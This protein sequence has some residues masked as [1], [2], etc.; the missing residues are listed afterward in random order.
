MSEL[1]VL[2]NGN[3]EKAP[4]RTLVPPAGP[5]HTNSFQEVRTSLGYSLIVEL[6]VL[7]QAIRRLDPATS[8][9][10]HSVAWEVNL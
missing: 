9:C 2:C 5:Q 4:E 10:P 8:V 7:A 6:S 1:V 3:L